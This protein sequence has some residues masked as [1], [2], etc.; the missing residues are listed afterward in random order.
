MSI[1]DKFGKLTDAY[2]DMDL[3]ED[4]YEPGMDDQ[5]VF[6]TV[7]DEPR[8]A[9]PVRQPKPAKKKAERPKRTS[10]FSDEEDY[11]VPEPAASASQPRTTSRFGSRRDQKVVDFKTGTGSSREFVIFQPTRFED[12]TEIVDHMIYG[13]IVLVNEELMTTDEARRITDSLSGAAYALGGKL[14]RVGTLRA[15][16][17]TPHGVALLSDQMDELES[18]VVKF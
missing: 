13:R 7:E 6:E 14:L 18:S 16:V 8:P 2:S 3:D 11:D 15:V 17:F 1:F 10:V 12:G 9:R 5:P 4:Y